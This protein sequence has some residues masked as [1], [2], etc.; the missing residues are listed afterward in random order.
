MINPIARRIKN[1]LFHAQ[2]SFQGILNELSIYLASKSITLNPTRAL[3]KNEISSYG[4]NA[5][6]GGR[7]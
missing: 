6:K 3:A 7:S 4:E 5:V 2:R 1:I